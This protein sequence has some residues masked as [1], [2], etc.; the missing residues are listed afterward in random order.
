MESVIEIPRQS[1]MELLSGTSWAEKTCLVVG[2][3]SVVRRGSWE[4]VDSLWENG[5]VWLLPL[6]SNSHQDDKLHVY[7]LGCP[8]SQDASHHQ[9][10]YIFRIGNP[11]LN[12]HLPQ[13]LG[14]GT[15]QFILSRGFQTYKH[16]FAIIIPP[17]YEQMSTLKRDHVNDGGPFF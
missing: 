8:P 14:G 13:L 2:G 17:E 7:I 9:E 1:T 16:S 6:T 15:T 4:A 10:Y 3:R 5:A 11:E 12:L